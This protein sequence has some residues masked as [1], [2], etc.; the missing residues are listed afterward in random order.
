MCVLLSFYYIHRTSGANR[1]LPDI[2]KDKNRGEVA[3]ESVSQDI[4]ETSE[5]N[6]ELYATVHDTGIYKILQDFF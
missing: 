4:Y 5:I 2:P 1:S 6:S 3:T